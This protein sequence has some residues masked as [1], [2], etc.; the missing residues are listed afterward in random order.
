MRVRLL[1][2]VDVVADGTTREVPGL[3]R[4]AV[5]AALALHPRRV[6]GTDRLVDIVW[7]DTAPVTVF[8]TLQTHV[9]YLRR[10]LGDRTVI[11]ALPPGYVLDIDGEATDVETAER[12]IRD[13]SASTDP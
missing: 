4:K 5:L 10:V 1:G 13:G 6:V 2:S 8:N 12:L 11:R 9:S 7:G 3:R